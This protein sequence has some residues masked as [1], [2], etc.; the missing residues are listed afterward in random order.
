MTFEL[1][2]Y[3]TL[4]VAGKNELVNISGD[5]E[6]VCFGELNQNNCEI[7]LKNKVGRFNKINKIYFNNITEL[8][9][10]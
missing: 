3:G 7:Y 2:A 4:N 9:T 1:L 10:I 8:F 5:S 6:K